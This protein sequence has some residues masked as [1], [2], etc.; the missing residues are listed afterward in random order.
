M[1]TKRHVFHESGRWN[2]ATSRLARNRRPGA[3][4][5]SGLPSKCD[6]RCVPFPYARP[7]PASVLVDAYRGLGDV[8]A[9]LRG[10]AGDPRV[11]QAAKVEA[12]AALAYIASGRARVPQFVPV[13]GRLDDIAVAAFAVR[14]LMSAADE[15]VLRAHWRGTQAGLGR[16]LTVTGALATPGGRWRQLAVA[17]AAASYA[18]DQL[19]AKLG[20]SSRAPARRGSPSSAGRTSRRQQPRPGFGRVVDGEVLSRRED[21]R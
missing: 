12:S 4:S 20:P 11:A 10:I 17:G 3:H 13:L 6:N 15:P 19:N 9:M 8:A 7:S 16:L 1:V 14:R 21:R 5:V 18:R 2:R